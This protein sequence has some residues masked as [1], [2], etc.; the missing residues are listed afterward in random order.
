MLKHACCILWAVFDGGFDWVQSSTYMLNLET[1]P[2][3]QDS[4]PECICLNRGLQK[5]LLWRTRSPQ[6]TAYGSGPLSRLHFNLFPSD[7]TP[8]CGPHVLANPK[9]CGST[10]AETELRV[11]LGGA[12]RALSLCSQLC[13]HLLPMVT[14]PW[15]T[16]FE[17]KELWLQKFENHFWFCYHDPGVG[18]TDK[19][20]QT[21]VAL[22]SR[23]SRPLTGLRKPS[24]HR[25]PPGPG[26]ASAK[27][28]S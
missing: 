21:Q 11:V 24:Y 15:E 9:V 28:L 10:K 22:W 23:R 7:L 12:L 20:L 25:S 27:S 13:S 3:L 17:H 18:L 14:L 6:G 26:C 16:S 5:V 19:L 4:N 2:Y 8:V 1:A